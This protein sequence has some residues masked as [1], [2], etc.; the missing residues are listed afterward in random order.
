[1][2][3]RTRTLL[4]QAVACLDEVLADTALAGLTEA[5]RVDVLVSAGAVFRRVEA[6]VV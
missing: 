1:M 2:P 6:V 5:E 3:T 4:D